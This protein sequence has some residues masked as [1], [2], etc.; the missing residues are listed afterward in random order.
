MEKSITIQIPEGHE[1]DKEKSTF[2]KI[3]FKAVKK[4]LPN[5]WFE[6]PKIGGYF[7]D[8]SS[9]I[10]SVPQSN[11]CLENRNIFLTE[12]QAEAARALAQLSQLREV[13]RDGWVPDWSKA[14]TVKYCIGSLDGKVQEIT[15]R[16]LGNFLS[17]Q[18]KEV[19]NE[20]YKNF[21]DLITKAQPLLS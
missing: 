13:Y 16:T 6:L 20:F 5:T 3:V 15:M 12:E 14:D 9:K 10:N 4:E 21:K 1:I 11:I 8:G 18:S 7:V 19:S 2:K 17:F